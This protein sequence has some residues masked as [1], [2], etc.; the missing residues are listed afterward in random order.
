MQPGITQVYQLI[1]GTLSTMGDAVQP[2]VLR[3]VYAMA[4]LV[5]GCIETPEYLIEVD[6]DNPD[7]L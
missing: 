7:I 3:R 1:E 5:E 6:W 4:S 2:L